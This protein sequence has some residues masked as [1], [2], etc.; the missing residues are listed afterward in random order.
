MKDIS[1]CLDNMS[2]RKDKANKETSREFLEQTE[3]VFKFPKKSVKNRTRMNQN[4]FN[5]QVA[6]LSY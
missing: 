5:T 1:V 6:A 2:K 4:M 3:D